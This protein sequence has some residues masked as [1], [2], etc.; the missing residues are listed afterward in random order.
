MTASTHLTRTN[1]LCALRRRLRDQRGQSLVEFV[2]ALPILLVIVFGIIEFAA[3]WRTYQVVTNVA[4]E[5][6][7][8]GVVPTT[9]SAQ[10][11]RDRIDSLLVRSNLSLSRRTTTLTCYLQGGGTSSNLC[12]TTGEQFEVQLDYQHTFVVLGPVLNL[13][14]TGC[15]SGY[16]TVTLTSRS[17][18]RDE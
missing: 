5:G 9:P 15:G 16:G 7:R 18:M 14:C 17:N 10:A 2:L 13:M 4:R 6:A 8:F 11:V 1:A 3:A 12:P